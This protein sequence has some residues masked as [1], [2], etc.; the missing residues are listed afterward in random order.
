[1]VNK[2]QIEYAKAFDELGFKSEILNNESPTKLEKI[3]EIWIKNRK[4][5]GQ[6]LFVLLHGWTSCA[7]SLISVA[8]TIVEQSDFVDSTIV[9]PE[10][11]M[12]L[13]SQSHPAII[14]RDV[15]LLIDYLDEKYDF[16]NIYLVGHSCGALIA[17]KAYL[18]A[19]GEIQNQ[20]GLIK[21]P[22]ED[23]LF[24]KKTEQDIY[25]LKKSRKWVNKVNRIILLAGINRGWKSTPASS[26]SRL[27]GT[28]FS[29]AIDTFLNGLTKNFTI[30][31]VRRG[32]SFITNLRIQWVVMSNSIKS[33]GKK[34]VLIIQLLGT[35][36]DIVSPEDNID[37]VTGKGFYYIDIP[38]TSHDDVIKLDNNEDRKKRFE[39][40]LIYQPKN[41]NSNLHDSFVSIRDL[42]DQAFPD[43][44]KEI[45]NVVFVIH[46]IRD[47]GFWTKKIARKIRV[48]ANKNKQQQAWAT[49]TS[50]YGY[51]GMLPFLSPYLRRDKVEWLMEQYTENLALYP[52]ADF[53]YVGHSNGTYLVAKAL[54]EYRCCQFKNIVFAGS[55]VPSNYK[56]EERIKSNQVKKVLNFVATED[57]V[58]GIFPNLFEMFPF[59]KQDLGGAGH[60]GFKL[61]ND[62]DRNPTGDFYYDTNEQKTIHQIEYI[63]GG[64]GAALQEQ[65]WDIIAN[66]IL[67]GTVDLESLRQLKNDLP[68]KKK[69]EWYAE[70]LGKFPLLVW[71]IIL[72]IIVSITLLII[73]SPLLP[74]WVK[75]VI[76]I[77]YLSALWQVLTRF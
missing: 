36:D 4:E 8:K 3:K 29:L 15:V 41:E 68:F 40:A 77:L 73:L 6:K 46:G 71:I 19:Y 69:R 43:P 52:N 18:C 14:A 17:R 12:S 32:S 28:D 16:E 34:E 30:F 54:E 9:I 67:N 65:N 21:A 22:F 38:K 44:N 27:F 50:S 47:Q 24:D 70:I 75:P 59:F 76:F 5:Q 74:I 37:F 62:G 48:L 42:D 72:C 63:V 23:I 10:L 11:P 26:L 39:A 57:V 66:F 45:K 2:R 58:V 56:W 61:E 1:M 53:H 13:L 51:F 60:K 35:K 25:S 49:E 64:H 31:R 7:N 55:V 33:E 20:E